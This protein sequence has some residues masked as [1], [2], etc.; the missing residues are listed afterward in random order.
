MDMLVFAITVTVSIA[1]LIVVLIACRVL[2]KVLDRH[3]NMFTETARTS[4]ADVYIFIEPEKL[5]ALIIATMVAI[6]ILGYFLS[7]N[8]VIALGA[9]IAFGFS[10]NYIYAYLRKRRAKI[11]LQ[12]LPDALLAISGMLKAG[13]NLNMALE[14]LVAESPGPLGQEF[15]LF[16]K[17]LRVGVDYQEALDNLHSRAPSQELSLVISGMKISR[18]I[19]GSL[20]EVLGRLATTLRSKLEMEGKIESLTAQGKYQGIVMALLPIF[21]GF[22]IYQIEP[23][24]MSKLFSDPI[25]WGVCG[26]IL[27]FELVGYYFIRKITTIDV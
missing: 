22:V 18:E 19:G 13:T 17:E 1:T 4:L 10:P 9:A 7:H 5:Y 2:V 6:F 3:K 14:T 26:F 23:H 15:G 27:V 25:G 12:E 21:L 11:F 20:A 8:V 16:L 24:A